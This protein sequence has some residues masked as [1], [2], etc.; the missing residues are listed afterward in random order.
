MKNNEIKVTLDIDERGL[1]DGVHVESTASTRDRLVAAM[2]I[3]EDAFR[4]AQEV[5]KSD[6]KRPLAQFCGESFN[7]MAA[8]ALCQDELKKKTQDD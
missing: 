5:N 2:Y 7:A 8:L 6:S 1:I 4:D 3:L